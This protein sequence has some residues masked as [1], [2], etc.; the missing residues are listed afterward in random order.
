MIVDFLVIE[1][2]CLDFLGYVRKSLDQTVQ[3][4]REPLQ[5]LVDFILDLGW[6]SEVH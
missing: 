1:I 4:Q 3:Y 5:V 6:G 2:E